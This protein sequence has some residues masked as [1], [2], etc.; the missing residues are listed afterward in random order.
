[1]TPAAL[2]IG[3]ALIIGLMLV[4]DLGL[5]QR[6]AHVVSFKEAAAWSLG[7]FVVAMLFNAAVYQMR[8]AVA[9]KQFFAGYLLELSLSVDNLFVFIMVFGYFGVGPLL[10]PRVL[11]WGILG[12]QIMRMLFIWAGVALI[13][14]FSWMI[15]VFGAMLIYTGAKMAFHKE[16][17]EVD[18]RRNPLL[19]LFKKFM[20]FSQEFA[21]DKF[22]VKAG[23]GIMATPLFATLLVIEASDVIF[24]L[25]SIPAIIAITPDPMIVYTSNIFAICGLRSLYFLLAGLMGMFRYLKIGVSLILCFVGVK[26]L[27]SSIYHIPIDFSL[28]MIAG[29]LAVCVAASWAVGPE[30]ETA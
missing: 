2:W 28:G 5:A 20:P 25:D 7:W 16:D 8:G 24:A 3:F 27:I 30:V 12:A 10:Q 6:K 23:K 18:P 26:M 29:I 13:Q 22:F 15:Y 1:M 4:L 14:T 19:R 17:E 21:G 9:A 11:H